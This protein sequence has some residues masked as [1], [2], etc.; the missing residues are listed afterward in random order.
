[1]TKSLFAA[2]M[3]SFGL[4]ASSFAGTTA[5]ASTV[6]TPAESA[7]G[8]ITGSV[9]AGYDSEYYFR[10]LWFSSNNAWGAVN[11]SMP[12]A[13]KLSFG[14]GALYT[15]GLDTTVNGNDI[16][17]SELDIIGSLNYDAGWSRIGLVYTNYFFPETFSGQLNGGVGNGNADDDSNI[18]SASDI[19]LTFAIPVGD[20]TIYLAGY[21]DLRIDATYFELGADYTFKITDALSI[22]PSVQLGYAGNEYYTFDA[23]PFGSDN[24]FT[25]LRVA[26]SAPYKIM[27]NLVLTPYAAV[28]C[29]M[30]ARDGINAQSV[31]EDDFYA[32]VSLSYSF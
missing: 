15:N 20:A 27:D 18:T 19:G 23:T 8:G 5:P 31:N 10:G 29:S 7:L 17:Y 21:Y 11:L 2:A 3:G 4:A 1:M 32:G 9:S 26:V 6:S 28:N 24:G 16:D 12:I 25:H 13:D 30:E 22:V 14:F